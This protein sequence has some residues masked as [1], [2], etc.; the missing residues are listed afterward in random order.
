MT[1]DENKFDFCDWNHVSPSEPRV[2]HSG[3][4]HNAA[5]FARKYLKWSII[6]QAVWIKIPM[7][8]INSLPCTQSSGWR[9]FLTTEHYNTQV[10]RRFKS[11][12]KRLFVEQLFQATIKKTLQLPI[13]GSCERNST[14]NAE[15]S[16]YFETHRKLPQASTSSLI[17]KEIYRWF[18]IGNIEL[19]CGQVFW[20][21]EVLSIFV[22]NKSGK[23][24]SEI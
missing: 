14:L 6:F 7:V 15:G 17:S 18:H 21:L 13:T 3:H 8:Y 5:P 22:C 10:S 20:R 2:L 19:L 4:V 11:L 16:H 24:L 9:Q 1:W 12:A 23:P